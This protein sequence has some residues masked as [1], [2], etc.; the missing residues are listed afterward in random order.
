MSTVAGREKIHL[1]DLQANHA[2]IRAEVE[3]AI[4]EVI[5]RTAYIGGPDHKAFQEEF[6]AYCE[7]RYAVGVGNGTD[8]LWLAL[9]G[10]GIGPGDE[11]IT[12]PHTFIA[13]TEAVTL[14]GAQVVFC[15]ID[16]RTYTLDPAAL[17]ACVTPR[18]RAII[19]VQLYGLPADMD[20]IRAV[21]RKHGLAI[22]EDA[23]QAHGARYKGQRVGTL[24]DAT[25]FSFYPG[26][27][28][29]GYGDG[30]AVVTND[31]KV[32]TFVRKYC[33]HGRQ[34][35]YEH[36]FEGTNSRLDGLQAAILRVKLRHLD[37]WNSQRRQAAHWYNERL[38]DCPAV[39]L[40]HEP[41]D[42][43]HVYHLYVVQVD[44]R[45]TILEKLEAQG[46]GAG[47]HYPI[48]LHLQPAYS[49]LGLREGAFP[50]T[51]RAARRILSLPLYPE[52][53]EAQVERVCQAVRQAVG[54]QRMAA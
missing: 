16:P 53:T 14:C 30:G 20:G 12:S 26:K 11:V 29:G 45:D 54:S 42:R 5:R 18:T 3:A 4:A 40:P 21:A 7:A 39:Q 15:D 49:R 19:A 37:H 17:E 6:A 48:P 25:A 52:I 9:L 13:S 8:A 31:E 50:H 23:A 47:V 43:E 35:K 36:D 27:N 33:N 38:R 1:V 41:A 2:G 10:L 22:V 34:A 44:G 32:A 51:E 28:L 46:I 24:G